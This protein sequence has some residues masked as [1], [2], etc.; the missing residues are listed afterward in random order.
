MGAVYL[1]CINRPCYLCKQV[2]TLCN[3]MLNAECYSNSTQ[4]VAHI[5]VTFHAAAWTH[6]H[7]LPIQDPAW[8]ELHSRQR[9]RHR[10]QR[11]AAG[12]GERAGEGLASGL[13][14]LGGRQ[15]DSSA[16][17]LLLARALSVC[18]LHSCLCCTAAYA[19][20]DFARCTLQSVML[21]TVLCLLHRVAASPALPPSLHLA[22][23]PCRA[24]AAA[25]AGGGRG[26]RWRR[27]S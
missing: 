16:A 3:Q 5:Q 17:L 25:G 14:L 12:D 7:D 15:L 26:G 20:S 6:D 9:R 8:A 27:P 4:V 22:A 24:A 10:Q 11:P 23:A 21:H 13:G 18:H 1:D 19:S 2:S